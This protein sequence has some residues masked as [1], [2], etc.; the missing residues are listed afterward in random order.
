MTDT[1]PDEDKLLFSSRDEARGGRALGVDGGEIDRPRRNPG[2]LLRV[3]LSQFG[4]GHPR[5]RGYS[6]EEEGE[7]VS[8]EGAGV[9]QEGRGG[10]SAPEGGNRDLA[11]RQCSH[12]LPERLTESNLNDGRLLLDPRSSVSNAM[13]QSTSGPKWAVRNA[14]C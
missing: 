13:R 8:G 5:L 10:E 6:Q 3:P 14:R 9:S 1:A 7:G 4:V 2:D 12:H 11:D